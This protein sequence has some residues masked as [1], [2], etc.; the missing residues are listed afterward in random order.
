MV[1]P[2]AL[3][4]RYVYLLGGGILGA[5]LLLATPGP[6]AA[7]PA[8]TTPFTEVP[9]R[10]PAAATPDGLDAASSR[11]S[12]LTLIT[13]DVLDV[14]ESADGKL[15]ADVRPA[16]DGTRTLVKSVEHAGDLYVIP[17]EAEPH[18]QS[19]VLD[20]ELFN[21]TRLIEVKRVTGSPNV[22][23]IVTYADDP[24]RRQLAGREAPD[25]SRRQ[26]TLE[27]IDGL[28]V[29]VR[30]PAATS[31]WGDLADELTGRKAAAAGDIDKV[32]LDA[33]VEAD[34]A[35]SVPQIGA[36]Q[37]WDAGYDGAG[38]KVAVL[39][40]GYDPTHPDLS[41]KVV[42]SSDFTGE[43]IVD[44]HGHG[45][46]VAATV[47][48]T[49][50][51]SD[52]SRVGVAPGADLLVGKVMDSTGS[53]V[54]S[55]L[56]DGM[57]WTVAQGADVVNMSLSTEV[58]DGQDPISAAV[59]NLSAT[60]DTL[61]VA[62]AGNTGDAPQT[63]RA[64]GVADSALSVAAVDKSDALASFSSRGPRAG[65]HAVKPD[66]AAPGVDIIAARAA[67]T[68]MDRPVD[69]LYTMASGTSMAA[70]H[71]A[72]AAAIVAQRHPSWGGE[73]IKAALMSTSTLL[74]E[75]V[76]D[77]GAGRVD[78]EAAVKQPVVARQ[79]V[80]DFGSFPYSEEARDPVVRTV[81]YVNTTSTPT[82]LALEV[83]VTDDTG[84][85]A[86]AGMFTVP[87]DTVTVPAN[88]T[89]EVQVTMDPDIGVTRLYGGHLTA[90]GPDGAAVHTSIGAYKEPRMVELVVEGLA[91]NGRAASGTSSVDVW[92]LDTDQWFSALFGGKKG[93]VTPVFRVPVGTY[94]ISGFL[95]NMDETDRFG[96]E[97]ALVTEPEIVI[98][99]DTR[100][101][102]DA[103]A[104]QPSDPVTPHD[105]EHRELTL[106]YHRAAEEHSFTIHY[107]LDRYTPT[108]F[109]G[110]TEPVTR[111]ELDV[112]EH[113]EL[114]APELRMSVNR[115]PIEA[116][117]A[118]NSPRVDGKRSWPVVDAGQ[119]RPSDLAA[120]DVKGRLALVEYAEDMEVAGA[121]QAVEEA[122]AV[123]VI[124]AYNQPGFLLGWVPE[125]TG[126][127]VIT[128]SQ[129]VGRRLRDQLAGRRFRVLA[130]GIP[131]SPY[132]YDLFPYWEDAVPARIDRTVEHRELARLTAR[133]RGMGS[134]QT[135]AEIRFPF[136]PY[137]SAAVRQQISVPV[138]STRTEWVSPGEVAWQQLTW[139]D[140]D[141]RDSV[142]VA[143]RR[144]YTAGQHD[145]EDW[146]GPVA[147]PGVPL[148]ADHYGDFGMPGFREGDQLTVMIRSILDSDDHY[149]ERL[150][151]AARFYENGE[152]VAEG[153]GIS[154]TLPADP[155][156]A[157]YRLELD[158]DQQAPWWQLST[159]TRTA[160][161]FDSARPPA[162]R[163]EPLGL[164]QL[165]YDV[166][167]DLCGRIPD[168]PPDRDRDQ[169]APPRHRGRGVRGDARGL[170]VVRRGNHVASGDPVPHG[171]RFRDLGQAIASR[172]LGEPAGARHRRRRQ[173]DRA[174]GHPR[175]RCCVTLR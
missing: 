84:A 48:G 137:D 170:G 142:V 53:G 158:V 36:P 4:R 169:R 130:E 166:A 23:L 97:L 39:D 89:A 38:T 20:R 77:A 165:D 126:I 67:G 138:P 101:V 43:G 64:P 116:E 92:N 133:Y 47:A 122:G 27:S 124:V 131:D 32:W 55:W 41:G 129:E 94:S 73:E 40:T 173:R 2:R 16:P 24:S 105:T 49:G 7:R 106:G 155:S 110:A 157:R 162:G 174:G 144:E 108:I 37:A 59:N 87:D 69:D 160:W 153:T 30:R 85:P 114:Y 90:T 29:D 123:A 78:V 35:E 62:T 46:H 34:L 22:P 31:F 76:Y 68:S 172:E 3:T 81:T 168:A 79:G 132:V 25:H 42:A 26:A 96:R 134:G 121:A 8:A 128:V 95:W 135:G 66:L 54:D 28:A 112:S 151:S 65:D 98:E 150:M 13:G 115:A 10:A 44:G 111:G 175:D 45:T 82:D 152:L 145:R 164:L 104:A 156:P 167:T 61:F 146:F 91:Q 163:R 100:L 107:L 149:S 119:A 21:V 118:L 75:S 103:T 159:R 63:V 154:G 113:W 102:L 139:A 56:I 171:K 88:G 99:G 14:R 72:G 60:S 15:L 9:G 140:T 120:A 71:V 148:D 19:D 117:Y 93:P 11:V 17:L 143:S 109:L 86:A 83:D 136:R 52:G 33:P 80:I 6:G 51:G 12:T 58:T 127:P 57:E 125:D 161:E 141:E 147:R 1:G 50:A 5:G 70:P 18:L 74:P